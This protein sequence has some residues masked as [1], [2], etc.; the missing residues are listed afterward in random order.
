MKNHS[1]A[2]KTRQR[3]TGRKDAHGLDARALFLHTRE[4]PWLLSPECIDRSP[5]K[6]V[7]S[8]ECTSAIAS[9]ELTVRIS[10][11]YV[12]IWNKKI[13]IHERHANVQHGKANLNLDV[14][15]SGSRLRYCICRHLLLPCGKTRGKDDSSEE[16]IR[17]H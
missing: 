11:L 15:G 7:I 2:G 3:K 6:N 13:S 12:K 14:T 5:A 16:V 4:H 9:L 8:L 10:L 1:S 17:P